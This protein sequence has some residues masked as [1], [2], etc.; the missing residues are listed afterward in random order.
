M[1]KYAFLVSSFISLSSFAQYSGDSFPAEIHTE[2]G[3]KTILLQQLTRS[4]SLWLIEHDPE[5][6]YSKGI[7][8]FDKSSSAIFMIPSVP[9]LD[10]GSQGTCVTFSTIGVIDAVLNLADEISEQCSLELDEALG[11]SYWN[12]A[13][14]SS[15]VIDPLKSYGA[16]RQGRCGSSSYPT[17]GHKIS[18]DDYKKMVDPSLS[19]SKV[20]YAYFEPMKVDEV[21]AAIAANHYVSFGFGLLADSA[22]GIQGFDVIVDGQKKVGGLWA[23]KQ[24]GDPKDYCAKMQAGHET[25]IIGYDDAQRL[26]KIRNSW[27][28]TSGDSGSYYMSY[29]FFSAMNMNGSEI[30][31]E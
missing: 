27:G 24:P 30:W 4:K 23:C 28:P 15:E 8:G 29:E 31:S 18:L 11:N 10:Q 16:V 12:G 21:K 1:I 22:A 25:Y 26:F 14:Q 13:W 17:P 7:I 19:V 6:D 3:N 5:L 2:N 9:V 20:K